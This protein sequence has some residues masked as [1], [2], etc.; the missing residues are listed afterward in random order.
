MISLSGK[1]V[2]N[3]NKS[4]QSGKQRRKQKIPAG[5]R[6]TVPRRG[7]PGDRSPHKGWE[8]KSTDMAKSTRCRRQEILHYSV[9]ET[10]EEVLAHGRFR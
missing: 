7:R 4:V 10:W 9:G 2:G 8:A 6:Q 5:M 1:G 3:P